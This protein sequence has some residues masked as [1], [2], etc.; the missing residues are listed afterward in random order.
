MD[1]EG[2]N[3]LDP[4]RLYKMNN[5]SIMYLS[6]MRKILTIQI[7]EETYYYSRSTYFFLEE[8]K[9]CCRGAKGTNI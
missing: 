1:Y 5:R 4:E 6:M 2:D 8:H 3:Y 7:R 9:G